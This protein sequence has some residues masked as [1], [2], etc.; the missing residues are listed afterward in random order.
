[1]PVP[2]DLSIIIVSWNTRDLL[3]ECLANL[4]RELEPD[5]EREPTESEVF[6][7][8][9]GSDDGSAEAV[10]ERH[11]WVRL[12]AL[13]ENR[14]YAAGNNV[15]LR[16]AGGRVLL[17]LNSDVVL[18]PGAL[19]RG[20]DVLDSQADVG[21]AG[22]QLLHPDGRL[23]NSIHAFPCAWHELVPRALLEIGFPRRYPSKRHAHTRPVEVDAVLGAVLFVR[24]EVVEKVGLLCEDYFFFLE[25]TDWCWRMRQAGYRVLHI[26]DS[27]AIHHSG[28]SSK[29]K[30]PLETRIEYHRSL[31]HFLR[32]HRGPFSAGVG[33][34]LRVIKGLLSLLPLAIASLVFVRQRSRL[35]SVWGV[36]SWHIRG[37][38]P[39]G[40]LNGLDQP[41]NSN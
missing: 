35:R 34:A 18:E 23:Q 39:G 1:M 40:G 6:V 37:C 15:A 26:P 28:A 8:D 16:K 29:Q 9:N 13:P 14:G 19:A 25:E 32:V 3:L 5:P 21:A 17:L 2:M 20:L 36:L 22:V 33:R 41:S 38:P 10:C 12:I 11:P 27:R 24:R 31:H 4:Q 7:V 30:H